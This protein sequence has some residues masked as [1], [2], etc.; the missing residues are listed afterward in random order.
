MASRPALYAL[1]LSALSGAVFA[2]VFGMLSRDWGQA[3]LAGLANAAVL[4]VLS[5]FG[6]RR[7]ARAEEK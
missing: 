3:A 5:F 7:R 6:L 4:F 1:V 2:A